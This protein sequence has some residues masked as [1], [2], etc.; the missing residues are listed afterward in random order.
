MHAAASGDV[1][2][3]LQRVVEQNCR[4]SLL[5]NS[6]AAP[7][8]VRADRKRVD[9]YLRAL[10][11]DSQAYKCGVCG[12]LF[13]GGFHIDHRM[14]VHLGGTSDRTNLWAL[15][16]TCH[17]IKTALENSARVKLLQQ[18]KRIIL[19]NETYN[20]VAKHSATC[21]ACNTIYSTYFK[22]KCVVVNNS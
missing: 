5:S 3:Y 10:I 21:T 19:Q 17:G 11:A 15:C 13:C 16:L 20:K 2:E 22:H 4:D 8:C 9:G 14:P 6:A 7:C 1:F 12:N 18:T